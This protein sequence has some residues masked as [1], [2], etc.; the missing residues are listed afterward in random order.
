MKGSEK[1]QATAVY[2][3]SH[4]IIIVYRCT[5]IYFGK[6]NIYL[7]FSKLAQAD[8]SLQLDVGVDPVQEES[9]DVIM[10]NPASVSMA[11]RF[12]RQSGE[13][14]QENGV[15]RR[16]QLKSIRVDCSVASSNDVIGVQIE[17]LEPFYGVIYSKGRHDDPK[18]R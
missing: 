16:V 5:Y 14:G 10:M 15:E 18:C 12:V 8:G 13:Y 6:I 3:F 2:R 11:S 1:T 17:F 7:F 9:G 4:N